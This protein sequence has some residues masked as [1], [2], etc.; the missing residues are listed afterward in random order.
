MGTLF[1]SLISVVGLS[2]A[3]YDLEKLSFRFHYLLL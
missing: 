1:N 2:F 3:I